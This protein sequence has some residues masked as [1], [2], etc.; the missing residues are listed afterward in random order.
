MNFFHWQARKLMP[1]L[2]WGGISV[3]V[4]MAG[5][6][7]RDEAT[8]QAAFQTAG[9]GAVDA[10]IAVVGRR[11]ALRK[12]QQRQ[13]NEIGVADETKAR[14]ALRRVLLINAALDVGYVTAGVALIR[15]PRAQRRGMG[16]G[17]LV[18]G[19]FLLIYDLEFAAALAGEVA[20]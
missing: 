20:S 17:I 10:L 18:Q 2:A 3:V 6:R 5:T 12:A 14:H 11:S 19:A 13:A 9:W 1:L 15:S 16:W 4:G 8:R 7:S